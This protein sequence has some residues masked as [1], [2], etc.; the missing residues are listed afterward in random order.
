VFYDWFALPISYIS[1]T[2]EYSQQWDQWWMP[3]D[4][5]K[6]TYFQFMDKNDVE[7]HSI[8]FSELLFATERKYTLVNH[9]N[10]TGL[11]VF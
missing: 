9:I 6:I 3:K 4:D 11:F 2:A 1:A 5:T 7:I 10:A 8:L